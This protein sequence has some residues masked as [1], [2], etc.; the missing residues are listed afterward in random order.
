MSW[1]S[2]LALGVSGGLL[3]CPTALVV[4]LGAISLQ[5]VAF[6]LLLVVAFSVGLA[7]V[8]VALGLLL[9][10]TRGVFQRARFGG[11]AT[12]VGRLV[13]VASSLVILVAGLGITL[14]ALPQALAL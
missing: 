11:R 8:L 6:G 2:L 14:A 12:F 4:L 10:Y 5:R 7:G 3:P 9:V 13:P 1:R